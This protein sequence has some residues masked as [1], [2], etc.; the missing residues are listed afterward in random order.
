MQVIVAPSEEKARFE[1][2]IFLAGGI[3]KCPDWQNEVLKEFQG[4]DVTVFNP[5]RPEFVLSDYE[6]GRRQIIW[7]FNRLEEANFFTMYFCNSESDQPIC[8][9]E[10][11][12]NLVR[13]QNRFP[14]DWSQRIVVSVEEGYRRSNDVFHQIALAAPGIFLHGYRVTPKSHA[15]LIKQAIE[16]VNDRRMIKE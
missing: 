2:K 3:S 10:L 7:E 11:G 6:A 8:M 15:E 13:F 9:Y 1:T 16:Y 12:R 4:L 5:R 14:V